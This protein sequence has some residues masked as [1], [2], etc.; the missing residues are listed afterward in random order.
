LSNSRYILAKP[1]ARGGMAEIFLAKSVGDDNFQ[2]IVVAKRILNHYA[3]EKE[4]VEMFRDEAHVGKKLQHANI[5][6]VYDFEELDESYAIIMEFVNG[7]DFRGVLAAAEVSRMR[8]PV[9]MAI[10]IVAMASR[11]LHYAH[12]KIDDITGQPLGIVHRDISPQ[13]ILVSYQGE[14][15]VTDFGIADADG[16]ITET[17]PG[18]VK[19]KYA[20]MS[21]EQISGKHVDARTDVFALC[22]VLWEALAMKRLFSGVNEVQTIKMVQNAKINEDLSALNSG[23]NETLKAIVLKGLNK[24]PKKRY[25]SAG[26]LENELLKFLNANYP[27]YNPRDISSFMSKTLAEKK[28]NAQENIKSLLT[29][30]DKKTVGSESGSQSSPAKK[31]TNS[32]QNLVIKF[33]EEDSNSN[34]K[35]DRSSIIKQQ[36]IRKKISH[37][38][39][40][41][42]KYSNA[43]KVP[44][45]SARLKRRRQTAQLRRRSPNILVSLVTVAA[46]LVVGY[47]GYDK[48]KSKMFKNSVTKNSKAIVIT[49]SPTDVKIKIDNQYVNDGNYTETPFAKVIPKNSQIMRIERDGYISKKFKLNDEPSAKYSATLQKDSRVRYSFLRVESKTYGVTF[50]INN[51]YAKGKTPM[52]L[53]S[54]PANKKHVFKGNVKTA[55]KNYEFK[56]SLTL[57]LAT[58]NNPIKLILDTSNPSKTKCILRSPK[59]SRIGH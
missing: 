5:V 23:V 16:K 27:E 41:P 4:F 56:C 24:D 13:N 28:S 12:T 42:S 22:V 46:L 53:T 45:S 49:S 58:R 11:G 34:L 36:S 32:S 33:T 1:I 10:S 8:V 26:E 29:Q 31:L 48:Y 39:L 3:K 30:T 18:I 59:K 6:Q 7:A 50:D 9:P 17:K 57:K 54:L 43:S 21:P 55:K 25:Q 37:N 47:F 51:G 19:G 40:A 14:V 2:R 15:K 38:T 35:I 52:L 20:Y 44:P